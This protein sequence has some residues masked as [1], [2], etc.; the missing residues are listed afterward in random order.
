MCKRKRLIAR[1]EPILS[2][3]VE[4]TT[5]HHLDA[6]A[7]QQVARHRGRQSPVPC[8]VVPQNA[9]MSEPP[10]EELTVFKDCACESLCEMF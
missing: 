8:V 6:S 1:S 5:R 10:G 4:V 7:A 9:V 3:N 2:Y